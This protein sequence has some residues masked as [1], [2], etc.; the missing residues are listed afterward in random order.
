MQA[1]PTIRQGIMVFNK[2]TIVTPKDVPRFVYAIKMPRVVG[3]LM[4]K[5]GTKYF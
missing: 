5:N 1:N 3:S 2:Y 4:F